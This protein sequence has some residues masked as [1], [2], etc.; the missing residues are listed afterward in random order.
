MGVTEISALLPRIRRL[1]DLIC[2]EVLAALATRSSEDLAEIVAEEGG[3]IVFALD[4][5]S[6]K[7]LVDF[8]RNEIASQVP[9]VLIA[10]GLP[11]GKMIL[12]A[13]VQESECRWRIIVDPIDGSRP[14]IYQKRS[15]WILTGVAPNRGSATCLQDIELAV[16]T[17]IPLLKQH[18][19]DQLWAVRGQ[20]AE[21]ARYNRLTRENQT[22]APRPSTAETIRFG[23]ASVS[24]FFP[25]QRDV[26]ASIDD[27]VIRGALGEVPPGSTMTFEDQYPST[28][29]QLYSL[30]SGADRFL[31]DL[32][33][34]MQRVADER[35]ET[36]GHCC[37]PYDI[38][39][40]LIAQELGVEMTA[41]DGTQ[42][43]VPLDVETPVA[44]VGYANQKIRQQV[45]PVLQQVLGEKH[46]ISRGSI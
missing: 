43:N 25:G 11:E 20:G 41:P 16:Q 1:H 9:V 46:L 24:R 30:A 40:L 17:E 39:T 5:V 34:L 23:Y 4:R 38:C 7:V 26:L 12:P 2:Q 22:I 10:E 35:G 42:L 21:A 29:G 27:E 15:G 6:E 14:L 36:L 32:R 37:H 44:W 19:G 3:D 13:G 31:A 33:P 8:I 18:L 45:E 28:G